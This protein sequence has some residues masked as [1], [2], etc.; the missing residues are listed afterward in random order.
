MKKILSIV[1][2]IAL[3]LGSFSFAFAATPADVAGSD[4]EEAVNT[5]MGFG[6]INGYP[7]GTYKPGNIVTRAEMAK[8]LIITLGYGDLA[9]GSSSF[10][11]TAGHWAD[12]YISLATGLNIVIGYPDG[13]FRPDATVTY[14]EAITMIIRGLGY[15]DESLPGVWP[16]DY[17]IKA[18]ELGILDDVEVAAGGANRGDVAIM[19]FNAL[20]AEYGQVN[21]DDI[22]EVNSLGKLLIDKLGKKS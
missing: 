1:L 21:A 2:A 20:N 15:T 22:W 9:G 11:D 16:T 3:V 19:L 18:L 7:D 4:Y 5:L 14:D 12:G 13:T 8:L 17:K 10:S 6:I